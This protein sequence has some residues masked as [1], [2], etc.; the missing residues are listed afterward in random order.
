MVAVERAT[1]QPTAPPSRESSSRVISA[2]VGGIMGMNAQPGARARA[3]KE[4]IRARAK[5]KERMDGEKERV[6][7]Q[8]G[9]KEQE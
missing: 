8:D 7:S 4:K 3:R 9:E 6:V 1:G 2:G 5:G